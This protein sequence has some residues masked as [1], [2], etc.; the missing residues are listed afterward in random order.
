MSRKYEPIW[1][2]LKER[3]TVRLEVYPLFEKRVRRM[4]SKEKDMDRAFKLMNEHDLFSL[5]F[6]YDAAKRELQIRLKQSFCI[7]D[8][9]MA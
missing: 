8:K 7:E 5:E 3:D 9:V 4:I 2:R 6:K 1:R